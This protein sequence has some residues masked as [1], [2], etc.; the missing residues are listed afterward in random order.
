MALIDLDRLET[1]HR[2][3]LEM[4][5]IARDLRRRPTRSEAL[6]W[7]AVRKRRLNGVRFRRQ[8]PLGPFVVD[9]FTAERKLIVEIDG[10]VHDTQAEADAE[11]Q[12]V[13]E[14]AGYRFVRLR[15]EDVEADLATALR[16]IR[17]AMSGARSPHP[18]PLSPS[19]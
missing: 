18:R 11:R 7:E 4:I 17:Y 6:L 19:S 3:R 12:A 10:T 9:F 1:R 15:S 16:A 13:I 14:S 5:Q 8:H 2:K